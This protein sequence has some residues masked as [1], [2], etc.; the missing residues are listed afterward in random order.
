MKLISLG[1]TQKVFAK[2]GTS[3]SILNQLKK[4][5]VF[6]FND[7]EKWWTR[8]T[9]GSA[10]LNALAELIEKVGDKHIFILNCNKHSYQ[11]IK[12]AT[13]L[14][15]KLLT[16]IIMRPVSG[17]EL[18]KIILNRHKIGG[19]EIFYHDGLV[20]NSK[21]TDALIQKIHS[22]SMGN[23]GVA[24][25]D[26]LASIEINDEGELSIRNRAPK[27]FPK[28]KNHKW[29]LLLYHFILHRKLSDKQL[30]K[31][32]KEDAL[33]SRNTLSEMQKAGLVFRQADGKYELNS[34]ARFHI[35]NWL[36]TLSFIN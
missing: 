34:N 33:L 4:S 23:V 13:Q 7:L 19:A 9:D 5:R 30:E 17:S 24:L 28:I 6:V 22:Q 10:C 29:K 2:N 3:L 1:R 25:H 35:E 11:L 16:T 27:A 18:R 15:T 26:W 31:M 32:L 36:K 14:E 20:H 21:K 12:K 8:T